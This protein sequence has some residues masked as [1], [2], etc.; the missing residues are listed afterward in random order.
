MGYEKV[1]KVMLTAGLL[2]LAGV[3]TSSDFAI[4]IPVGKVGISE[5]LNK[6]VV[7]KL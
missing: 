4:E 3:R 2:S 6:R 7:D 1:R 5:N